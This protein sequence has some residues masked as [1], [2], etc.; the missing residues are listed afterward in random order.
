MMDANTAIT[1]P[2]VYI[3]KIT[4]FPPKVRQV[5]QYM[6][7]N[8]DYDDNWTNICRKA[9]V[10]YH[11]F[12]EG[13][14]RRRKKGIDIDDYLSYVR[15]K[16]FK[17]NGIFVDNAL[18]NRAISGTVGAIE[19]FYKRSGEL[20]ERQ[21]I[22]QDIGLHFVFSGSQTPQDI[23]EIREKEK[24][25]EKIDNALPKPQKFPKV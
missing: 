15:E 13:V 6:V 19:L 8:K 25:P 23:I 5:I 9:N 2:N 20:I 11:A 10:D 4:D 3:P 7:K 21:E 22:R 17:A 12:T 24:Q 18:M 16:R 14:Y 1:R